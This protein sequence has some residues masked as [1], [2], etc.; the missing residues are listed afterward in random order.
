M[1]NSG[2]PNI[3]L[4]DRELAIAKR[5]ASIAIQE[6]TDDFYKTVGKTVVTRV[7]IWVGMLA[8]GFGVAKGWI[9]FPG[10]K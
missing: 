9:S 10:S 5:A 7:L 4:T 3:E 6:L 1:T 8:L 2:N